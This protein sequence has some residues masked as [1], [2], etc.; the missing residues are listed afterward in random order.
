M[1]EYPIPFNGP[2]VQAILE[3][4]KHVTRRVVKPQPP[5]ETLEMGRSDCGTYW[6][7]FSG[8]THDWRCPYGEPGSKLWVRETWQQIHPVGNGQW[9]F[10]EPLSSD[11]AKY[12]LVYAA[13]RGR[14]EPPKWRPSIHMPRWASRITLEVTGVRVERVQEISGLDAIAEGRPFDLRDENI[15][16]SLRNAK[17]WFRELWDSINAKSGNDWEANPWVWVVEFRRVEQ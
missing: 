7:D 13:D 5:A 4:R 15:A 17:A 12:E 2:M 14:D 6:R 11:N 8:E 1:K 9:A 3:K 10:A 16:T